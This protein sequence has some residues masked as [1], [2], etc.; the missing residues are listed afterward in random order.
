MAFK[1]LWFALVA[2]AWALIEGAAV[3]A[4][5]WASKHA[6]AAQARLDALYR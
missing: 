1:R 6:E 4:Y 5:L 2:Y 3:S